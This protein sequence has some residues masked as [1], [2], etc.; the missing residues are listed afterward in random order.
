MRSGVLEPS[1]EQLLADI[2]QGD[3]P[4]FEAL[5]DRLS[6]R[7]F[8]LLVQLLRSE[9]EA[10]DALQEAFWYV[11][12]SAGV[13]DRSLGSA[14]GWVMMVARSRG[15]DRLRQRRRHGASGLD[16]VDVAAGATPLPGFERPANPVLAGLP[17]DQR[18]AI[19]LAFY[20]GLTRE[21]IARLQGVPVGTVKTRIRSGLG[22]M[23][24]QFAAAG[25]PR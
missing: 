10:E 11:W 7:V 12:R 9:S 23:R 4:A 1:D 17:E 8:G 13:F 19:E 25:G 24:E 3:R 16:G 2:A 5:Y 15:M 22:R 6:P 14:V 20:R 21:Q 18:V